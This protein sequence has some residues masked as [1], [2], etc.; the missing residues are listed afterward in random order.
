[1]GAIGSRASVAASLDVRE[2]GLAT[3]DRA[4]ISATA[5]RSIAT[6]CDGEASGHGPSS[7]AVRSSATREAFEGAGFARSKLAV[8]R[9]RERQGGG[10]VGALRVSRM[11]AIRAPR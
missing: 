8:Q 3:R 11:Q 10:E 7:R 9:E 5:S 6:T 1:M 4:S 2:A